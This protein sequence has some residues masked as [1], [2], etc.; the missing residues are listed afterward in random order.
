[1]Q[2]SA[3]PEIEAEYG[4]EVTLVGEEPS[5]PSK[6]IFRLD[7]FDCAHV[8]RHRDEKGNNVYQISAAELRRRIAETVE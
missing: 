4:R 7:G 3:F 1:M 5:Y 8:R 6:W 2:Y